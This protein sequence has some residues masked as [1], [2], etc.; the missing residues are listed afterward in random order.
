MRSEEILEA[1]SDKY[2][3]GTMSYR[4]RL[5]EVGQMVI[6]Y[7]LECL[8]EAAEA[9]GKVSNAPYDAAIDRV[10][11]KLGR[12]RKRVTD[13][14]LASASL[15]MLGGG[16]GPGE[17]G[18]QGVRHFSKFVRRKSRPG[19]TNRLKEHDPR[20]NGSPHEV[21]GEYV[22]REGFEE[23]APELFQRAAREGWDQIR[24]RQAVNE[25]DTGYRRGTKK[26]KIPPAQMGAIETLRKAFAVCSPRDAAEMILQA[27]RSTPDKHRVVDCLRS[28]VPSLQPVPA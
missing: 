15:D 28:L 8:K 22:I 16:M 3:R 21:Y 24:V 14:V 18:W 17:M 26:S 10:A 23:K 27:L 19:V 5:L 13:L 7:C 9:G 4:D 20:R 6:C 2:V 11:Q 25:I 12:T 1:L